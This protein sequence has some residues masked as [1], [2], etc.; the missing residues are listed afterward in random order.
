MKYGADDKLWVVMDAIPGSEMA[1]IVCPM[2]LREIDPRAL[3]MDRNPTLFTS[4][5]EAQLEGYGR[6]V[7]MRAAEAIAERGLETDGPVTIRVFGPG[8]KLVFETEVGKDVA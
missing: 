8:D 3:R 5:E 4:K 7:A 6:L 2:S 1:D